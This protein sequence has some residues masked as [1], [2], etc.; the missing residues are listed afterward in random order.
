MRHAG[1][2]AARRVLGG[3]ALCAA[4]VGCGSDRQRATDDSLDSLDAR[5]RRVE[6]KVAADSARRAQGDSGAPRPPGAK[7]APQAT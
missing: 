2:R 5:L 4:V 6:A 3:G 7:S 1:F